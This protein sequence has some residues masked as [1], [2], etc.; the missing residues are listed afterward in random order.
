MKVADASSGAVKLETR[1]PKAF[2]DGIATI[3]PQV[4]TSSWDIL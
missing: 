3:V 2:L 4:H 1:L